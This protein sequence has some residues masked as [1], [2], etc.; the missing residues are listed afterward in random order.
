MAAE[1]DFYPPH[2]LQSSCRPVVEAAGGRNRLEWCWWQVKINTHT[3]R[4][5][6]EHT[7]ALCGSRWCW[8]QNM[9]Q[10]HCHWQSTVHAACPFLLMAEL[11]Q[12]HSLL[13]RASEWVHDKVIRGEVGGRK[14]AR[15]LIR[16]ISCGFEL[17]SYVDSQMWNTIPNEIKW[18]QDI[19]IFHKKVKGCLSQ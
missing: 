2:C 14:K 17:S 6:S 1:V 16:L 18:M 11:T 3:H 4:D 10:L 9:T 19:K 13:K 8:M 5:R 15:R 12:S 7:K